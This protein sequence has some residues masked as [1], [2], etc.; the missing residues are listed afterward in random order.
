[1][2]DNFFSV[3]KMLSNRSIFFFTVGVFPDS[4]LVLWKKVYRYEFNEAN[5]VLLFSLVRMRSFCIMI[6]WV[7]KDGK[8][9]K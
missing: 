5:A 2:F 7:K 6:Q 4:E 3:L 1:M 8:L 9:L